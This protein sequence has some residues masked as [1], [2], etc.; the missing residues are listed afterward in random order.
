MRNMAR[1]HAP[2]QA[3]L[4]G[5]RDGGDGQGEAGPTPVASGPS[6]LRSLVLVLVLMPDL[7]EG[8]SEQEQGD[9]GSSPNL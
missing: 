4:N 7:T 2:H 6:Q 5:L 8:Q 9:L 3:N 1:S